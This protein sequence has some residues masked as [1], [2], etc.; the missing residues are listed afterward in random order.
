MTQQSLRAAVAFAAAALLLPASAGA[1][2]Q[3]RIVGSSTVYPFATVV[4]EAFGKTGTF[5]TPIVESTGTGGGLKLFCAGVGVGQPDIATASRRIKAS[6]VELCAKNG[7]SAITEV[8]I[9]YDGI[10]LAHSKQGAGMALTRRE[11]FLALAKEI[12]AK[13]GALV[14]NPNKTW[15]DVDPKFPDQKIEVLGPPPTSGTRDA[16][17]ELAIEAGCKTFP[18]LAALEA[19][20][21]ARFKK[22]CLSIREDGAYVE[23]GENDN[24]IVQKLVANPKALGVFGYSF[25]SEN[26]DVIAGDTVEGVTPEFDNIASGKYPLSRPLFI[27]VKNAHA[28]SIPGIRE[29]VL[30]FASDKAIGEFG[31]LVDKGLIPAPKPEREKFRA[32]AGQLTPLDLAKP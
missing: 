20:D 27:Y 9:G 15:K 30:E 13:N 2:D 17:N 3:I 11:I 22:V 28:S 32:A 23:A 29:Y 31:Y 10:V 24:L 16:F 19:S 7:V 18:E 8:K 25:L 21:N 6:E 1:R 12:P 14:A 4:A 5:K 26:T